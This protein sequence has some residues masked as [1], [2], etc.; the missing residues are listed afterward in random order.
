MNL[1][2]VLFKHGNYSIDTKKYHPTC[3]KYSRPACVHLSGHEMRGR[4]SYLFLHHHRLH[5]YLVAAPP[6]QRNFN[7]ADARML[8]YQ[9][10]EATTQLF[11][12]DNSSR[13][14]EEEGLSRLRNVFIF[15]FR[16]SRFKQDAIN[17]SLD[18]CYF[19][20]CS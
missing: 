11:L 19:Y 9:R 20:I 7:E 16:D 6:F 4:A 8:I 12:S 10:Q 3:I 15:K 1:Q 5:F 2:L 14:R 13:S 17:A 18:K